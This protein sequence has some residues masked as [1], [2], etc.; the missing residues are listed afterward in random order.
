MGWR[1]YG[2]LTARMAPAAVSE[3]GR[4]VHPDQQCP[5]D[6]VASRPRRRGD[7][8]RRHAHR[9]QRTIGVQQALQRLPIRKTDDLII[10]LEDEP[11]VGGAKPIDARSHV[12][13]SRDVDLPTDGGV[14]DTGAVDRQARGGI[15]SRSRT[16]A[17]VACCR[18]F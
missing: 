8:E 15:L 13:N 16:H 4:A 14:Q 2:F 12:G 10:S 6:R 17:T 9:P 1:L 18:A 5:A 11:F 3:S 7:A